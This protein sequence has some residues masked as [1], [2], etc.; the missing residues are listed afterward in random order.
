MFA[1][2]FSSDVKSCDNKDEKSLADSRLA[3][4]SVLRTLTTDRSL[5]K[6]ASSRGRKGRAGKGHPLFNQVFGTNKYSFNTMGIFQFTNRVNV[7]SITAD[8]SGNIS[9]FISLA[10][11]VC[12]NWSSQSSLFD[13]FRIHEV[14]ISFIPSLSTAVKDGQMFVTVDDDASPASSGPA[15]VDVMM[16]SG[17]V[18]WGSTRAPPGSYVGGDFVKPYTYKCA[19][20][21]VAAAPAVVISS[22][23][24]AGLG[25]W[26]D[27][28][29]LTTTA[30]LGGVLVRVQGTTPSVVVFHYVLEFVMQYRLVR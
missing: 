22:T 20:S 11:S 3:L 8:G 21:S 17:E 5:V 6:G 4:K 1:S 14:R 18:W 25:A 10:P 23:P 7:D 28:A 19:P 24:V 29:T 13:E 15:S 9:L 30:P 16:Q 12:T 27:I 2:L 26:I